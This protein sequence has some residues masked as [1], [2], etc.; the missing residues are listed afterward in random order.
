MENPRQVSA[1]QM[2]LTHNG[3]NVGLLAVGQALNGS[4]L[5]M[6]INARVLHVDRLAKYAAASLEKSR[7]VFT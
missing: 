6:A 1:D 3:E 4:A 2:I 5:T 7:S